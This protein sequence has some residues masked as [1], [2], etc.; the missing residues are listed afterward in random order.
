MFCRPLPKTFLSLGDRPQPTKSIRR[1]FF[2]FKRPKKPANH[3]L[4]AAKPLKVKKKSIITT[5][6]ISL[7]RFHWPSF[8]GRCSL[9]RNTRQTTSTVGTSTMSPIR[10]QSPILPL[11]SLPYRPPSRIRCGTSVIPLMRASRARLTVATKRPAT[12][13]ERQFSKTP[14][15]AANEHYNPIYDEV[16]NEADDYVEEEDDIYEDAMLLQ[17]KKRVRTLESLDLMQVSA[18]LGPGSPW[19]SRLRQDRNSVDEDKDVYALHGG[20]WISLSA[21]SGIYDDVASTSAVSSVCSDSEEDYNDLGLLLP[22]PPPKYFFVHF[23]P[24]TTSQLF[25]KA[26]LLVRYSISV[27]YFSKG[28]IWV[29]ILLCRSTVSV[30]RNI[31]QPWMP[32]Q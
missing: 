5:S 27:I 18:L 29:D 11:S 10:R 28:F 21:T 30:I 2:K 19:K 25:M 1:M 12:S 7:K 3:A 17:K 13:P 9:R 31:N 26:L 6:S 8:A 4:G 20:D 14:R 15:M 22:R 23:R 24:R 16:Y 32:A